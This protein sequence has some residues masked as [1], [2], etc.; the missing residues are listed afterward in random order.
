MRFNF[1]LFSRPVKIDLG[2]RKPDLI[3]AKQVREYAEDDKLSKRLI[4]VHKRLE[5]NSK[6]FHIKETTARN[7]TDLEINALRENGFGVYCRTKNVKGR[8][9]VKDNY[10]IV[11]A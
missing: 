3:T 8:T 9:I 5:H 7:L 6:W 4:G 10:Y 11:R 1:K 2:F